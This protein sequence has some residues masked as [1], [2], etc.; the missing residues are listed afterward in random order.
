MSRPRRLPL[1]FLLLL[2]LLLPATARADFDRRLWERY[3]PL[4]PAGAPHAEG[5]GAIWLNPGFWP[6]PAAS[7][8][9]ADLRVLTDAGQEVPYFIEVNRPVAGPRELSAALLNNSVTPARQNWL[10]ARLATD[11]GSY[12]AVEIV[13]AEHDFFRR[14]TVLG[15][16]DGKAWNVI[17]AAAVV[18]DDPREEQL[19]RLRVAIPL[20]DYPRLAV[21]I[22]NQGEPVLRLAGLRVLRQQAGAGVPVRV[23][24]TLT[25]QQTDPGRQETVATVRPDVAY[26][27]SRLVL[28]T[29]AHNFRRLVRVE[30]KGEGGEWRTVGTDTI[31]DFS[32]GT[33]GER[34]LEVDF[35]ETTARELRLVIR[36]H[37]SPPLELSGVS[38]FGWQ[39]RLVFRLDGTPR[40]FLFAGNPRAKAPTYDLSRLWARQKGPVPVA[41]TAGP[42]RPNADFAGAGA[43]LPFTERYKSAIYVAV[44]LLIAGLALL[45]WRV[46]R[47]GPS[48]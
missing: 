38:A 3:Q 44:T 46:L 24:A 10:E 27:V 18:F 40:Y 43:R 48:D 45:Q 28:A 7:P 14:L 35:P 34:E 47:Q 32:P 20:S 36:N 6:F 1:P 11:A 37:D 33:A 5:F 25:Q 29:G 31:F 26:P 22:D 4:R 13:T 15:S 21:R 23:A 2:L 39:R 17:R 19:R 42:P 9:F 12:D 16:A 30:A 8:P 41:F